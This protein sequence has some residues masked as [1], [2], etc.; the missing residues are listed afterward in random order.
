MEIPVRWAWQHV[1]EKSLLPVGY[2][3]RHSLGAAG[4]CRWHMHRVPRQLCGH[5]H[6]KRRKIVIGYN[7]VNV[8]WMY[9]RKLREREIERQRLGGQKHKNTHTHEKLRNWVCPWWYT[10]VCML[11]SP[12]HTHS[13]SYSLTLRLSPPTHTHRDT[14]SILPW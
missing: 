12:T 8:S 1:L 5:P 14:H 2:F 11:W 7:S 9:T 10:Y 13:L 4:E 6:V 3:L